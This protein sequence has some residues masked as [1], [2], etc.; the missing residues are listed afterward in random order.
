M[1]ECDSATT[2]TSAR[3]NALQCTAAY[4]APVCHTCPSGSSLL[5]RRSP[6]DG[7]GAR[8]THPGPASWAATSTPRFHAAMAVMAHCHSLRTS[9]RLQQTPARTSLAGAS[10]ARGRGGR[11]IGWK[12]PGKAG[13]AHVA[14][15]CLHAPVARPHCC[16]AVECARVR[17]CGRC[18]EL[19][20]VDDTKV[21]GGRH[22]VGLA[23]MIIMQHR[24]H[25]RHAA[26]LPA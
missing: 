19:R 18:Y 22:P 14:A 24:L 5:M 17:S 6:P 21:L 11:R 7:K 3:S 1:G 25:L 23:S 4:A 9:R 10:H 13:R 12:L 2:A 16:V 20:C 8:V 15:A 26:C